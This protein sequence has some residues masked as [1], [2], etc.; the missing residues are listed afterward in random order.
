MKKVSRKPKAHIL[1]CTNQRSGR[2]VC[3]GG[4]GDEIYLDL[5]TLIQ[6]N[7]LWDIWV[8]QTSCL[9]WC[10]LEGATLTLYPEGDFYQGVTSA[11]EVLSRVSDVFENDDS[12]DP[13]QEG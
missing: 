13:D 9:G 10:S 11:E 5:K 12:R 8:T 1:V 4:L 3:C 7:E 2:K 6:D